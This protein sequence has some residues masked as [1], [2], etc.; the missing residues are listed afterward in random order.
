M[1]DML[2]WEDGGRYFDDI[3]DALEYFFDESEAGIPDVLHP[4]KPVECSE[5][6]AMRLADEVI[7][8]IGDNC[9]EMA[10][11]EYGFAEVLTKRNKD[12]LVR[13]LKRWVTQAASVVEADYKAEPVPFK[14]QALAYRNTDE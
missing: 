5:N 8:Y 4:C 2:Y 14:E 10:C 13:R 7:D 3:D 9:P 12:R 1:T 6:L 11:E